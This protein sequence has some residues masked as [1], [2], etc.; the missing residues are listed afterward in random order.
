M[1]GGNG[2]ELIYGGFG[3]KKQKISFSED[4]RLLMYAFGDDKNPRDDTVE[5]LE[6]YL[7]GFLNMLV[8]RGV[9]RRSRR[10]N[11]A[12]KLC[13]E[14]VLQIIKSDPKWLARVCY[15]IHKKTDVDKKM[16]DVK[17]NKKEIG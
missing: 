13:K 11:S 14:D 1:E 2:E 12:V 10:D 17:E 5:L 16:K 8:Q 15:I 6:E 9:N 7:F 4:L 3:R